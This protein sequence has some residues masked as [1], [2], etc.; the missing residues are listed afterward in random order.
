VK[1]L[2]NWLKKEKIDNGWAVWICAYLMRPGPLARS[3]LF[4]HPVRTSPPSREVEMEIPNG[5]KRESIIGHLFIRNGKILCKISP[6][7]ELEYTGRIKQK[8]ARERAQNDCK[9]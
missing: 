4:P 9:N 8:E 5:W 6:S 2:K 7:S 1:V 3:L